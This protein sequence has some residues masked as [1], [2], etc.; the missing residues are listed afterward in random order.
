MMPNNSI[1]CYGAFRAEGLETRDD[2]K[3]WKLVETRDSHQ[4]KL[5]NP[6]IPQFIVILLIDS[7]AVFLKKPFFP[8]PPITPLPCR[9][10]QIPTHRESI[11]NSK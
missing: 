10:S 4:L 5:K 2:W 1:E 3:L 6:A 11:I 8:I 9:I 7:P